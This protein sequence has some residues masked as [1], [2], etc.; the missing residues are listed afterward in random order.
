MATPQS[1]RY[2]NE[3]R[4]LD[5]LLKSGA[6]SR[7][8][9]ARQ[10]GLN[11]S[12][13]GNIIASLMENGLVRERTAYTPNGQV[14]RP[15]IA[16][17]INPD[18]GAFIGIDIGI[19]RLAACVINLNAEVICSRTMPLDTANSPVST[20]LKAMTRLLKETANKAGVHATLRAVGVALPA[21]TNEH[22]E[23]LNGMVLRWHDVPLR[24]LLRG[25]HGGK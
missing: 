19:E 23:V 17:E 18:G 6:M 2:F 4:A 10:V 1:I 16:V 7:A 15:G 3:T 12:S 8:E 20:T 21:L 5:I 25:D 11:R 13:M 24:Q 14:G 9:L 22:G